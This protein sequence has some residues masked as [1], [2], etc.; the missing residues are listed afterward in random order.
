MGRPLDSGRQYL[1]SCVRQRFQVRPTMLDMDNKMCTDGL[2]ESGLKRRSVKR[3]ISARRY[4]EPRST[5]MVRA[6]FQE[7]QRRHGGCSWWTWIHQACIADVKEVQN[8]DDLAERAQ[9][10][11]W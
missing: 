9:S 10:S 5:E 7:A 8:L 11:L 6:R 3:R 4:R 1:V 2:Q